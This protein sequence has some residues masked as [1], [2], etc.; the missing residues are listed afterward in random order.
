MVKGKQQKLQQ[1]RTSPRTKPAASSRIEGR[2]DVAVKSVPKAPSPNDR[3]VPSGTAD[4]VD[5]ST[6]DEISYPPP[7]VKLEPHYDDSAIVEIAASSIKTEKYTIATNDGE[8]DSKIKEEDSSQV[9]D[10]LRE[11]STD[12]EEFGKRRKK[13]DKWLTCEQC[14][15]S[16]VTRIQLKNH[17]RMHKTIECPI[18]KKV[19]KGTFIK[20]HQAAHEGKFRCDICDAAFG[21]SFRLRSHKNLVHAAEAQSNDKTFPCTVC[22]RTFPNKT[23][24]SY[25]LRKHK[26]RQCP[27]CMKQV[28]NVRLQTHIAIHQKEHYCE[29]CQRSFA[30]AI[31]LTNHNKSKHS[32]QSL[33]VC[34]QC[35][36][37][38]P[39]GIKLCDHRKQ[40]QRKECPICKKT[41]RE[42]KMKEHLAA[43]DGAF[44]C[45]SCRKKL[46]TKYALKTHKC[47]YAHNDSEQSDDT[48]ER[49]SSESE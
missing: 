44:R 14:E 9:R 3:D 20:E 2:K 39:S 43:H 26:Q 8:N 4:A 36:R 10:P 22:E 34:E 13:D 35:G 31:N 27:I 28:P 7:L 48:S 32:E 11:G 5:Q 41:F 12:I 16:F 45:D 1:K 49:E 47:K 33:F 29:L 19:I 18:C 30:T 25:H 23:K 17:Q 6:D 46:S 40:H 21:S 15:R 24:L 38:F 42:T 37:T